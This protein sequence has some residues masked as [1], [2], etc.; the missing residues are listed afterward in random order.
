MGC[1]LFT[2]QTIACRR[3][4]RC[5]AFERHNAARLHCIAADSFVRL[6]G[7]G[8]KDETC[9]CGSN[10][11]D[12]S[13]NPKPLISSSIASVDCSSTEAASFD[14]HL[15]LNLLQIANHWP[16]P[17]KR[18]SIRNSSCYRVRM[19][20]VSVISARRLPSIH[21]Q[22]IENHRENQ[23]SHTFQRADARPLQ[24]RST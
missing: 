10:T 15:S 19:R 23:R 6:L 17:P 9:I 18:K 21:R 16:L 2:I 5:N 14:R 11:T 1:S 12:H 3:D 7:R 8:W 13:S 20:G 22:I 4:A 24:R